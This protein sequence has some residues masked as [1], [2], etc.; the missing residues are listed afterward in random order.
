[1][2]PAAF[3]QIRDGLI[4]PFDIL[5]RREAVL[6]LEE[7]FEYVHRGVDRADAGHEALHEG[8]RRR[9]VAADELGRVAIEGFEGF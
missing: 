9:L 3:S 7:G 5:G 1:M 6:A 4:E 8:R 2:A